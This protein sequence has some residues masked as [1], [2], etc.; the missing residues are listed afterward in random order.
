MLIIIRRGGEKVGP[1]GKATYG[2]EMRR[3]NTRKLATG[4]YT[5][6]SLS[7][8]FLLPELTHP[9]SLSYPVQRAD[10]VMCIPETPFPHHF[11]QGRKRVEKRARMLPLLR[12]AEH[13]PSECVYTPIKIAGF[14]SC[15]RSGVFFFSFFFFAGRSAS[16]WHRMPLERMQ[17]LLKCDDDEKPYMFIS[18]HRWVVVT[19]SKE[20]LHF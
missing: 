4:Q 7:L 16:T 9:C 15:G 19:A 10:S 12:Q 8:S 17:R 1:R 13:T 2:C 18:R 11:P 3:G 14:V 5:T 20:S 6:C